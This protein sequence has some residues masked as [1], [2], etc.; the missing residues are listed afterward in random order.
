MLVV[1]PWSKSRATPQCLIPAKKTGMSLGE[2]ASRIRRNPG[3]F[4]VLRSV[5]LNLLC[6]N[7]ITCSLGIV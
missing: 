5:A 2:N 6:F 1:A 4:A 3:L 7:G